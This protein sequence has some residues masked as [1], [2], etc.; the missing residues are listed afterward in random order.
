MTTSPSASTLREVPTIRVRRGSTS[1]YVGGAF[2]AVAVLVLAGWVPYHVDLGTLSNLVGLFVLVILAVTWNLMAGYGGMISIGQ[3]AFIGAGGYGVIY[4]ADTVGIPL[5]VSVPLAGVVC[6][7]LAL[8]TS[9]LLFRLAGGYFAI[10]TWVVAE[11]FKLATTQIDALGGGSGLSL[12]AFSGVDRVDRVAQV[13]WTALVLMVLVVLGTYLVMRS[14]L[15]LGLTAIRDNA[16]AASSLGV[17]VNRSRRIVYVAA[18][19]GAGMAGALIA[20]NS[21]RVSPDSIYSVNYSAFMIFI[22]VI[23]GLGS[24]EGPIIGAVVFFV[25]EQELADYGSWYLVLLGVVAI[26]VVLLLPRGLW[27]LLSGNGRIQVFGVGYRV[28]EVPGTSDQ[29]QPT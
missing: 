5:L 27:G 17:R 24:I 28:R 2:V 15:G 6:A 29:V 18:S 26:A 9:F 4:L 7:L 20:L 1:S 23:G 8:P 16:T 13:Y 25:L 14:R 11:V 21:L 10:G 12:T 22:V 19:A 3:Q